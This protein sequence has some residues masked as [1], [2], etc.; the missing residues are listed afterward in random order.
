MCPVSR[1]PA[2]TR[3][4]LQRLENGSHQHAPTLL[5]SYLGIRVMDWSVPSEGKAQLMNAAW[6]EPLTRVH[7]LVPLVLFAPVVVALLWRQTAQ[8]QPYGLLT[9]LVTAGLL[10]WTV[11]EYGI[12]RFLFHLRPRRR[13]GIVLAYLVHGVHHAY[14]GDRGRLVMP[15]IVTVPL[16]GLFYLLF[17]GAAGV[18]IGEGLFAGFVAGYVGYDTAHY[19][20][21]ARGGRTPWLAALRRNHMMHHF[22]YPDRRFGVSSTF[23]DHIFRT[24]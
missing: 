17:T 10:L 14:P 24:R 7:P 20:I 11:T 5:T 18:S 16:A 12:H 15:P 3:A 6:L 2:S 4:D 22:Q 13:A 21:H 23:W 19:A 8:G 1:R 9:A